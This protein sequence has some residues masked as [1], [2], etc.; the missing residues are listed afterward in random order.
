[1]FCICACVRD[2]HIFFFNVCF[3]CCHLFS[4]MF[5]VFDVISNCSYACFDML[6]CFHLFFNMCQLRSNFNTRE[7]NSRENYW[8]FGHNSEPC[9]NFRTMLRQHLPIITPDLPIPTRNPNS[10]IKPEILN[11][12]FL[13]IKP[14]IV[15]SINGRAYFQYVFICSSL[16]PFSYFFECANKPVRWQATGSYSGLYR[17]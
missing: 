13:N 17:D 8:F 4:T 14:K 9:G 3:V 7:F 2:F 10:S 6:Y 11:P 5:N 12:M 1:M 16:L 15:T